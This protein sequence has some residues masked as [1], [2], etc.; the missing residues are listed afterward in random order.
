MKNAK[1]FCVIGKLQETYVMTQSQE[2]S[3]GQTPM[4]YKLIA[5]SGN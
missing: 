5:F 1:N 3:D 2:Q 4:N